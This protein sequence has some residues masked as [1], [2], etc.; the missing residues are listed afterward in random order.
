MTDKSILMKYF[1]IKII[2]T[3][4]IKTTIIKFP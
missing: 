4:E 1:N 3:N 2:L